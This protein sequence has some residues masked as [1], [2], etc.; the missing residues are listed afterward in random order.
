MEEAVKAQLEKIKR[1]DGVYNCYVTVMEEEALKRAKEVQKRLMPV[2]W[3]IH[4]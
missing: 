4:L 3:M 2:N 1:T